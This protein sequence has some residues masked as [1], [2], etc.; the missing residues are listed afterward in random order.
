MLT[1]A[2][3]RSGGSETYARGL[4]AALG[5]IG[6]HN[7]E[8]LTPRV[9][10][11]A[12]EG[13]P[14]LVATD[15]PATLSSV[16][17]L[18][19]MARLTF[20]PGALRRRLRDADVVHY[21]LTLPIPRVDGPT[22]VTL[23]DVQHLDLPDLFS[24]STLAY[25]RLAYDRASERATHVIVLSD[26]TRDR[27]IERLV[28]DPRRVHAIHSGID[29]ER[30]R[31]DES[32]EREGF[33]LYPARSWPHKNH[34]R[35]FEAVALLRNSRPGLRLVLTS[36]DKPVPNGVESL[37][38]VSAD[39]LVMLYRRAGALVFPSLYEGFGLP[40]LEAMACGCP[41]ASST[42][43]SLAEVCGD[44]AVFFDPPDPA[45]IAAAALD[46]LD[47]TQELTGRGL[48]HS[49]TFTWERT[50]SAHEKIYELAVG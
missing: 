29:H 39:E 24:R 17:R 15:I 26:W 48:A 47:R 46:A 27:A 32:I 22:V 19:S 45:A 30:F 2:P 8:V 1:L 28:L 50:A 4:A 6:V 38:A 18:R 43:G 40:P 12:G 49:A 33:L 13:L 36:Y 31:P 3:P 20:A 23:H 42:A 9:A 14:T 37:G 25:R 5:R 34:E 10:P 21:P 44:A 35:L 41:V 11:D 7:Y 16:G